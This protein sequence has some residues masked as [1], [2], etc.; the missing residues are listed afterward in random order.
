MPEPYDTGCRHYEGQTKSEVKSR[1]DCV[2]QCMTGKKSI[3][4]F[5][6]NVT[7][8]VNNAKLSKTDQ[9]VVKRRHCNRLC[10]NQC[11]I[12]HYSMKTKTEVN[13]KEVCAAFNQM[14]LPKYI[15]DRVE[16]ELLVRYKEAFSGL[17]LLVSFG[18]LL[19]LWFGLS[20][21]AIS[22]ATV[23]RINLIRLSLTKF[24]PLLYS[25]AFLCQIS[26]ALY[27]YLKYET[28]TCPVLEGSYE[29][30]GLLPN[31]EVFVMHLKINGKKYL[32][33]DFKEGDTIQNVFN[34]YESWEWNGKNVSMAKVALHR[35]DS[36]LGL[37]FGFQRNVKEIRLNLNL[38]APSFMPAD[39]EIIP[40]LVKLFQA[41]WPPLSVSTLA[42]Y[43]IYEFIVR[44]RMFQMLAPPYDTACHD[45]GEKSFDS[46][47]NWVLT[48][49]Y[50]CEAK[51]REF[52]FILMLNC[53][54]G[55]TEFY[56]IDKSGKLKVLANARHLAC[57]K[58]VFAL[59]EA[60]VWQ[61]AKTCL[62]SCAPSCVDYQY[63]VRK[64]ESISKRND[65][66]AR[67]R[68]RFEKHGFAVKYLFK[69]KKKLFDLF[70][71]CGSL[72]TLWFGLSVVDI[73]WAPGRLGRLASYI[74][75]CIVL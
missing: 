24:L 75:G 57:S 8:F 3:E 58:R 4:I 29:E 55:L 48:G 54:P 42:K 19:S 63:N 50:E 12:Q 41:T 56:S 43:G 70:Y 22:R 38:T 60:K 16:L 18:S 59:N 45:D 14:F 65:S 30:V 39:L 68:I 17:F 33:P 35:D 1:D 37:R 61:A 36:G 44:Q 66:L 5:T 52:H 21:S 15:F 23:E 7:E 69:P 26:L 34:K 20:V 74:H 28:V 73:F 49:R 32:Y 9:I 72:L 25:F 46:N 51:C 47:S 6:E 2:L 40:P 62:E 10:P 31:F 67:V 71:E 27:R 11:E 13:D 64:I 53:T